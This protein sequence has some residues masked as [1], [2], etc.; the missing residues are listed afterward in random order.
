MKRNAQSRKVKLG[1]TTQKTK[2]SH[3]G[4]TKK[5]VKKRGGVF[6]STQSQGETTLSIRRTIWESGGLKSGMLRYK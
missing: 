3:P 4:N 2:P 1:E 5:E 6:F